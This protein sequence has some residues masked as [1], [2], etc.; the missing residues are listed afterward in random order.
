[1]VVDTPTRSLILRN[2][3]LQP[4]CEGLLG[5]IVNFVAPFLTKSYSDI[6]LMQMPADL[7]FTIDSVG[8]AADSIFIA[9]KVDWAKAK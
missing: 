8:S 7:P 4:R 1:V 9:G 2:L 3:R 5:A 6:S